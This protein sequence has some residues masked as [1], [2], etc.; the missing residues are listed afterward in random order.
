M[1]IVFSTAFDVMETGTVLMAVMSLIVVSI[2]LGLNLPFW[3]NVTENEEKIYHSLC[4]LQ[5]YTYL[6]LCRNGTPSYMY[7]RYVELM[8]CC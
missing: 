7:C 3:C 6:A 8:P 1:G 5:I 2:H 4:L